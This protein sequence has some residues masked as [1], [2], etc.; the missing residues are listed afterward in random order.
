MTEEIWKEIPGSGWRHEVSNL[1]NVRSWIRPGDNRVVKAEEP[2][3][4]TPTAARQYLKVF[5]RVG[6]VARQVLVHHL[7]AEAFI[8]PRPV[9]MDCAHLDGNPHNNRADNLRWVTK[10]ENESHKVLHGTR[11]RGEKCHASV[12]TEDQAREV[13]SILMDNPPRGTGTELARKYGVTKGAISAI[14]HG[15]LWSYL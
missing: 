8:G 9:G 14:K 1:G 12:L 11:V 2:R 15:R 6:G 5:L 4:L 10:K 7:V 3:H 13:K